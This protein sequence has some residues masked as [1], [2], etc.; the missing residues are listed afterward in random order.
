MRHFLNVLKAALAATPFAIGV[1]YAALADTIE[2]IWAN[3]VL[4]GTII[5]PVTHVLTGFNNTGTYVAS[6]T[7]GVAGSTIQ[8]GTYNTA[9]I[10]NP[11]HVPDTAGCAVLAPTPCQ[12]VVTFV[13]NTIPADPTVPFTIGT[14]TFTNGT[15]NLDSLI[16]GATLTFIDAQTH[17]V[18]GSDVVSI[19]TTRNTGNAVQNADYITL[20][21]LAGQSFNV[22]EGF[23]AT[24]GVTGVIDGLV[25]LEWQVLSG[26][27][28]FIG[29]DPALPAVAPEPASLA[30][31]G[32]GLLG[33]GL[34]TFRRRRA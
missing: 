34:T 25:V 18:L 2:G 17:A 7:N 15:S 31:L 27:G 21:G 29:H 23:T 9:G 4:S 19:D 30:L 28:G 6:M 13:G 22:E 11:P 3:P 32:T 26:S 16:F 10:T 20:S 1:P 24:A 12:S 8:W 14:F 5:D 33:L